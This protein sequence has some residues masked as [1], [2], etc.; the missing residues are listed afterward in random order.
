MQ[1]LYVKNL[2]QRTKKGWGEICIY[3]NISFSVKTAKMQAS[4]VQRQSTDQLNMECFCQYTS[5]Q[6]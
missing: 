3:M 1:Q 4:C 2:S 5:M 6:P